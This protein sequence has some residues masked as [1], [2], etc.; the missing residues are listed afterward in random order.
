VNDALLAIDRVM[1]NIIIL[2]EQL[3]YSAAFDN[4]DHSIASGYSVMG[5]KGTP[6]PHLQFMAQSVPPPQIVDSWLWWT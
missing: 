2:L 5:R 1:V 6:F 4:V 3:D